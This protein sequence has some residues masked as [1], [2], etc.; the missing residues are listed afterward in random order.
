M[1]CD[2]VRDLFSE[3]VV[4]GVDPEDKAECRAHLAECTS[5]REEWASVRKTWDALEGLPQMEPGPEMRTRFYQMLEAY[6][7]GRSEAVK[8]KQTARK[9]FWSWWPA[10]PV[11]QFAPGLALLAAVLVVS[12]LKSVGPGVL[13]KGAAGST[14]EIAQLRGEVQN[15]RQLVTLS[16][17]QQQSA[18][19]RLQGVTWSYRVAPTDT[20]VL[21]ALLRTVNHDQS[22]DVRLSAV[23]ALKSFGDSPIARR[24]L[25]QSLAKQ[26]SPLVEIAI[27]D[28]IVDLKDKDAVPA[29]RAQLSKPE[30]N[31]SVQKRLEAAIKQLE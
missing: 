26:T 29:I 2:K 20:E 6:E 28:A 10:N 21:S 18:S 11:W 31:T 14:Q 30:L 22:V 13:G 24:G 23:D 19:D 5:C 7:Q 16:L 12:Q 25:V 4:T 15:M 3:Y 27:V 1:N 9:G 17:L 8:D